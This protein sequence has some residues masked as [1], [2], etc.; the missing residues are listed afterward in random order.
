MD[1]LHSH[2]SMNISKL[3]S[4][5]LVLR[6][7][8][9][10]MYIRCQLFITEQ[11]KARVDC[12]EDHMMFTDI[13]ICCEYHRQTFSSV[14]LQF[15]MQDNPIWSWPRGLCGEADSLGPQGMALLYQRKGKRRKLPLVLQYRHY[16]CQFQWSKVVNLYIECRSSKTSRTLG[17]CSK[18]FLIRKSDSR[19]VV[20]RPCLRITTQRWFICANLHITWLGTDL[21]SGSSAESTGVIW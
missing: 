15:N 8:Q 4:L 9:Y 12:A 2:R 6:W 7:I 20:R 1:T 19:Q 14:F 3:I 21:Y 16:M 10:T 11:A 13:Q 17:Q 5:N 18:T